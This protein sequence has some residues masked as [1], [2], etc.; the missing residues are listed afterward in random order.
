MHTDFTDVLSLL[1]TKFLITDKLCALTI[2]Y[3]ANDNR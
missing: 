2:G 3:M 1:V